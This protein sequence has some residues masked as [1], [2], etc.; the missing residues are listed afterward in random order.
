MDAEARVLAPLR[1]EFL[2]ASETSRNLTG[3]LNIERGG[4]MFSRGAVL[5]TRVLRPRRG[6]DLVSRDGDSFA[7]VAL[8]PA[9]LAV[10]LRR[11]TEQVVGPGAQGLCGR[12]EPTYVAF[13]HDDQLTELTMLVFSGEEPPGPEAANT[14]LCGAFVYEA[15]DGAR[16]REGVLLR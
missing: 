3:D 2:A 16:T 10:E 6:A 11:V 12:H 8:G 9:D 4:L 1:G 13:A 14:R 15:P 5:Y 7:A